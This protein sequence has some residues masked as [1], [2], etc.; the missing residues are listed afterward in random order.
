[1][2]EFAELQ[3]NAVSRRAFLARMS[4]AGLGAAATALLAGCGTGGD[5]N[6]AFSSGVNPN[7]NPS[8]SPSG[9]FDSRNF[10]G[11]V[12]R[13]YN[14]VVLNYAL[15]LEILEADLYRQALNLA[16]GRALTAPLDDATPASG[17]TGN[18][19]LQ[20]APG[21]IAANLVT[22]AFLYLVQYAYV[23]AA[24]R[25]FL[26]TALSGIPGAPV[27]QANPAGYQ[28]TFGNTLGSILDLIYAVEETGV[29]AYEGAAGYMTDFGLLTTA[30]AIHSTEARHSAAVAYVLGR[31]T[32]PVF[33][34]PGVS[35]GKRVTDNASAPNQQN[36]QGI[37]E[38]T[39]NYYSDPNVV[40][41]AVT[42]FFK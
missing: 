12:G 13:N 24:H 30:V 2:N 38:N 6:K 26:R 33:N 10:P 35:A 17:S 36:T 8:P 21:G 40:I 32:G 25:D 16:S 31:N 39:F 37:S 42:P 27:A 19:R 5:D 3:R 7:P 28:A 34:L 23:E 22:P 9:F 18:Y 1:L 14:E 29:R 11:V 20:V 15:T 41:A 4:A